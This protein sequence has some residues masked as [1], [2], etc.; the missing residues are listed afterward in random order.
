MFDTN[1]IFNTLLVIPI[2]NVLIGVYKLL[3]TVGVPG[4]LGLSLIIMTV[5]IRLLLNPLMST[6]LKSTQKLQKLKPELDLLHAKHKNDKQRLQQEQLK[7]YQ[8]AGINPAAGCLPLLIQMP[9]LIA[10]YNLFFRLL[11]NTDLAQVVAE[12]NKVVYLPILKINSLD[13]SFFGFNLASKPSDWQKL[14]WWF[15]AVPVIT[16]LLQYWQTKLMTPATQKTD[17]KEQITSLA[18]RQAKN[19]DEKKKDEDMG[20]VMQK[21]MSIMMPLMI[22]FFAYSFPL[23]LSLYWNTFTVFGIIQQN[24]INKQLEA[25]ENGQNKN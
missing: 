13:L 5:L 6:Q 8:Q 1:N 16:G 3:L 2:L 23:G 18:G 24:K 14:G 25:E 15:L 19:K 10:I 9:I 4:A 21:Q 17:N 22:G 20:T 7:L 11:N 12:I